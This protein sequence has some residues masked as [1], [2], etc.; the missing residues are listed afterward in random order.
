M[1]ETSCPIINVLL[2][3]ISRLQESRLL[4]DSNE[5]QYM[6]SDYIGYDRFT[7]TTKKKLYDQIQG[8]LY[9]L[10]PNVSCNTSDPQYWMIE[11]IDSL[12]NFNHCIPFYSISIGLMQNSKIKC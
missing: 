4:F 5:K 2:D 8:R 12:S 6:Q 1:F 11:I 7:E 3:T 10:M 9:E